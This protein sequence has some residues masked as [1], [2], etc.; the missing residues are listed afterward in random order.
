MQDSALHFLSSVLGTDGAQALKRTAAREPA[1]EHL[2]VPRA[3]LAWLQDRQDYE[4]LVPGQ[5]NSYVSFEKSETGYRGIISLGDTNYEF[6]KASAEHLAAA[7]AVSVGV[8]MDS[9]R[10]VRDLTLTRLG[11]SID[12]LA[13]AH[14]LTKAL[15]RALKT[16]LSGQTAPPLKQQGPQAP[17]EPQKQ[18]KMPRPK[19]PKAPKVPGL[20]VEKSECAL[21]C[22]ACGGL[23]FD[24]DLHF[25][26]CICFTDMA[27]HIKTTVY[28][29]G[30]V[31]DF[32][33]GF[34]TSALPLLRKA[35][36]P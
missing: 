19:L 20:R 24:K 6:E 4:G 17:T 12:V 18:P 1:L 23:Q 9:H 13:K 36:K 11:K 26:G 10:P 7:V 27:K 5:A 22:P 30:V 35:L 14:E 16:E 2:L 28:G 3:A 31:L 32:G 25:R 8:D 34:Q 29:D 15:P 33:P 21:K